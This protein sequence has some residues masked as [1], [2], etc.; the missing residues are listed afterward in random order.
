M[1]CHCDH[2]SFPVVHI[3]IAGEGAVPWYK[4]WCAHTQC[5]QVRLTRQSCCVVLRRFVAQALVLHTPS[6][7][8]PQHSDLSSHKGL[9]DI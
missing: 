6:P 2:T 9:A 4:S 5:V 1:Q 8:A 3:N 7:L